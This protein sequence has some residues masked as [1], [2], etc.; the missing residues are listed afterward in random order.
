MVMPKKQVVTLP[1]EKLC[2]SSI[3]GLSLFF[4]AS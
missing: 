3:G 1:V 2:T 4:K